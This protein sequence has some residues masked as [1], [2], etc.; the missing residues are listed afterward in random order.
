MSAARIRGD[1][2]VA[3]L[4]WLPAYIAQ[5]PAHFDDRAAG[6]VTGNEWRGPEVTLPSVG[7]GAAQ[8]GRIHPD[9]N[10]IGGE[11]WQRNTLQFQLLIESGNHSRQ[12]LCHKRLLVGN[13]AEPSKG[14]I[15]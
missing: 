6:L 2:A 4:K 15:R 5:I 11:L 13:F 8:G 10:R 12:A 7:V 3:D 14:K 9:Q 1:Y